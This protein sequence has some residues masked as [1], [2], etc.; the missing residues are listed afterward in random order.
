MVV[1]AI[2]IIINGLS[3]GQRDLNIRGASATLLALLTGHILDR[4]LPGPLVAV[5]LVLFAKR[6][7]LD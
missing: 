5:L 3:T 4:A 6:F 1:P 7:L 2:G